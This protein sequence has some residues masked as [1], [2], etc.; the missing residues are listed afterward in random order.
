MQVFSW[1]ILQIRFWTADHLVKGV[2][3]IVTIVP[4]AIK[5]KNW[6]LIY[7]SD[8]VFSS[9]YGMVSCP[10]VGNMMWILALDK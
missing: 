1:L 6:R 8:V 9:A 7:S 4:F 5:L 2:G 3:Q 10:G